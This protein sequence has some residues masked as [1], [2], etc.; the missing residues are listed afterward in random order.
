VLCNACELEV[1]N[2]ATQRGAAMKEPVLMKRRYNK[3]GRK[4]Y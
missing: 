1:R 2:K 3:Q 4:K